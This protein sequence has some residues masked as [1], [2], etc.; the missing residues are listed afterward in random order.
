MIR[1]YDS[2]KNS[3]GQE[4]VQVSVYRYRG[5]VP[6]VLRV[7]PDTKQASIIPYPSHLQTMICDELR[8]IYDILE[9]PK[10]RSFIQSLCMQCNTDAVGTA[11]LFADL[12]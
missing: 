10:W 8:R 9:H 4:Y 6:L 1:L 11:E 12:Y 3:I 5:D 2:K 7:F